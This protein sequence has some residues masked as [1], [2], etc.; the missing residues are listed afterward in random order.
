VTDGHL[1]SVNAGFA[2]RTGRRAENQ[3]Y[4]GMCCDD[5]LARDAHGL[6]FAIADGVSAGQGGRTAAELTVRTFLDGYYTSLPTEGVAR[7]AARVMAAV[8]VW[9]HG[10]ARSAP[11]LRHASTT[12]TS[13]ILQGRSVHVLHAGDTRAYLLREGHLSALTQD[14]TL[15]HPDMSHVLTRAVGMEPGLRLDHAVQPLRDHDRL[16]LCTD[17]VHGVLSDERLRALLLRRRAS[18]EDAE[19]IID[20]ALAAGSQDNASCVVI[21][22]LSLPTAS[23]PELHSHYATLPLLP[24]P[25]IGATVD[26]FRVT[27]ALSDGRYSRL[28]RAVDTTTG[29]EVVLK[30]PQPKVASASTYHLAFVREAWVSARLHSPWIGETLALPP[31]RQTSLY[32]VM[33]YYRGETLEQRLLRRPAITLSEGCDIAL[34]LSK[35]LAALHRAGVIHRDVKPDN[36]LLT[37]DGGLRLLDLGIVRLPRFEDF[38]PADIPGTP[39]Y[40]APEL[41]EGQPGSEAS[42]VFALGVTLYRAFSGRY[43]YGEIEAF[44][45]PR[46]T[47]PAPLSRHR[48]ELPAWL[49]HLLAN[50]TA[51]D[52]AARPADVLE[53]ASRIESGLARGEPRSL[54]RAS[55][56]ERNPLRFWQVIAALLAL[57]LL[58]SLAH[59]R[60]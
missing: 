47:A 44:S 46:F 18:T 39:S 13:L 23:A 14:H 26:G 30:F 35:A 27:A 8:N 6:A 40:M 45:R 42:D 59:H 38:P 10:I 36:V 2:S 24:P 54:R 28:L 7:S 55:L 3:D 4:L 60:G 34:K 15:A 19:G 52:P 21:D 58:V 33:P 57:A 25:A 5:A 12:F 29:A 22:V 17:G 20:E 9:L 31:E 32:A 51:V 48:P 50:A 56:Y 43:P 53:L 37:T 11:A 49:G 16:L 1:L 41:F